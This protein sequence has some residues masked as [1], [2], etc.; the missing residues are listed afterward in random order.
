[1]AHHKWKPQ[2]KKRYG[3]YELDESGVEILNKFCYALYAEYCDGVPLP[4][5]INGISFTD[6]RSKLYY[7]LYK[8]FMD[9]K[10]DYTFDL[11]DDEWVK[12]PPDLSRLTSKYSK[13]V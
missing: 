12:A 10:V 1:M 2:P 13:E 8:D 5:N 7:K 6:Y 11:M 3:P 4:R 9:G